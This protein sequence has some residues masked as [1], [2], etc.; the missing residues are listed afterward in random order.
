ML[1][2]SKPTI[3]HGS[4][5]SPLMLNT[6]SGGR[7]RG[8]RCLCGLRRR[9]VQTVACLDTL[10]RT[11]GAPSRCTDW[12]LHNRSLAILAPSTIERSLAHMISGGRAESRRW[13]AP[14]SL[15]THPYS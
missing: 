13:R 12:S 2:L 4:R 10:Q 8:R 11:P 5:L 15:Y 9:L 6:A 7:G 14:A 3:T 1:G